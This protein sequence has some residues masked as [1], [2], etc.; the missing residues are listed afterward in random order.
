MTT[1]A[2]AKTAF[3]LRHQQMRQNAGDWL[4]KN[5]NALFLCAQVLAEKWSTTAEEQ[6]DASTHNCQLGCFLAEIEDAVDLLMDVTSDLRRS[7]FW[8]APE[9]T[10]P[11][12]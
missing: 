10:K 5:R 1:P 9:T 3:E 11:K 4:M 2:D 12:Q 8:P 7:N 6:Q